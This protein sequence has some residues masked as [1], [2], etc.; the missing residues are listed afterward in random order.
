MVYRLAFAAAAL[1]MLTAS[2]LASADD[3][4]G[5]DK[6]LHAAA[7]AAVGAS[8]TAAT[9]RAAVGC[10]AAAL[11]GAAKEVYDWANRRDMSFKDF[12]VTAA[13]GCI[14]ANGMGW[15]LTRTGVTFTRKF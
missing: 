4:T 12:A 8:V 14:A 15:A 1:L 2:R 5:P 11:A 6:T 3:W 10:G 7:G 13:V 9:G